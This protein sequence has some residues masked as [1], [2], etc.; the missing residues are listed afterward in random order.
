MPLHRRV[1]KRGFHN[2]F[3]KDIRRVNVRD[4]NRFDDGAVVGPEELIASGLIK[5]AGDGVKILGTGTLGKKLTV[6]AH[7]FSQAAADK[8]TAAGGSIESL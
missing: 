8:I 6:K 7:A 4:L 3:S 2:P 1:P 5:K